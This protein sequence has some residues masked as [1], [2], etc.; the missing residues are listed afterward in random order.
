MDKKTRDAILAELKAARDIADAAEAA[1]RDLTGDER[2]RVTAH[3][4]KAGDLK[5]GDKDKADLL[6]QM[7]DLAEGIE[8]TP[9]GDVKDKPAPDR[10]REPAKERRSLGADFVESPEF[11]ALLASV[12]G[13]RFGEKARVQSQPYG[14]KALVTGL[15]ETSAGSLIYPQQLGML[16]P[17]YQRPLT[18]RQ[19]VT[20]GTT[21]TDTIEYVR[22]LNV[23]NN[24]APVPEATS[25]AAGASTVPGGFKPESG[26]VFAK[27]TT[28]VKTI[29]HWMPATK[30]ALS[31][32]GQIKTLI[33]SFLLY[34]LEEELEDQILAGNGVGE[35][36]EGIAATSG[37]QAQAAPGVGEDVFTVTR[38]ARRLVRTVGR[39]IPT[40]YVLNPIDWEN[41]ELA[42]NEVGQF[43]GAGP[44]QLTAPRLWGLPVVESEAVPAG[45]GW[46]ADWTK[47]VL[48]DREQ[49]SIQVTDSHAD[50]FIRNLVAILAELRV[51][52]AVL[53]PA[54]FV[55]IDLAA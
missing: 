51:A 46:C 9:T 33:D 32:A 38:R 13:G 4:K 43:Y 55:Q 30:R 28:N 39:S 7:H 35:N 10:Y 37:I 25:A 54:A 6:G 47:A 29:A 31:D 19:L 1:D 27:D 5:A 49:A 26:M 50:F 44:F 40:A 3:L 53:R 11:K 42:R 16:D 18:V 14:V 23:T 8:V 36:L 21:G 34:G 15:D 48:W 17:F 52:F 12:P 41:I 22:L 2:G 20:G 45:T 24:A